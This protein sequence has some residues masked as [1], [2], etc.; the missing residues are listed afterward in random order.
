MLFCRVVA[1]KRVG[2]QGRDGRH[3]AS[4]NPMEGEFQQ[5]ARTSKQVACHDHGTNERGR[6]LFSHSHVWSRATVFVCN[7]EMIGPGGGGGAQT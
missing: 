1:R 2:Q 4:G 6:Y 7:N 3:I 5:A